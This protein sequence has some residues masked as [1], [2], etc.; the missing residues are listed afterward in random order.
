MSPRARERSFTGVLLAVV[1][2]VFI[3][4]MVGALVSFLVAVFYR[5]P[6]EGRLC[7]VL[8]LFVFAAVLVARISILEGRER[9]L[10]FG[11]ALALATLVTSSSLVTF[12]SQFRWLEPLILA[13]FIGVALWSVFQLTWDCTV[14]DQSR[15][16]SAMGWTE[17][18]RQR[19]APKSETEVASHTAEPGEPSPTLDRSRIGSDVQAG[20]FLMALWRGRDRRNTPGL[21]VLYFALGALPL[22]A[23]GQWFV[24]PSRQGWAMFLFGIY[25][26]A[27]LGLMT[28][29]S[30]LGL[31]RYLNLRQVELP[32][33]VAGPWLGIGAGIGLLILMVVM[34]LPRLDV[35]S[36]VASSLAWFKSTPRPAS[37]FSLGNDGQEQKSGARTQRE[38][39]SPDEKAG[40][41]K[42]ESSG[43][44]QAG[45]RQSGTSQ[46]APGKG[47]SQPGAKSQAGTQSNAKGAPPQSN[48]SGSQGNPQTPSA[49][50]A[51]RAQNESSSPQA[52]SQKADPTASP[53]SNQQ[54]ERARQ[55]AER[56]RRRQEEQRQAQA[57]SAA[58]QQAASGNSSAEAAQSTGQDSFRTPQLENAAQAITSLIYLLGIGALLLAAV[59]YRRELAAAWN[60]L[61]KAWLDWFRGRPSA[62]SPE[63]STQ[64]AAVKPVVRRYL[65]YRNPF[66]NGIQMPAN[67]LVKYSF[68]AFEALAAELNCGRDPQATPLEFSRVAMS[69]VGALNPAAGELAEM[70]CQV[71]YGPERTPEI[72]HETL[73]RVWELMDQVAQ[74]ELVRGPAGRSPGV[75]I[76][77]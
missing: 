14:M 22:F 23:A 26:A 11:V 1:G 48:P 36:S 31:Q 44:Q 24:A 29:T 8:G 58:R 77:T 42:S 28:L 62:A 49:S 61:W 7:L 12:E 19:W 6:H 15:D 38:A 69:R 73:R 5:G 75:A 16:N 17:R 9:A 68:A 35:E 57:S 4:F 10:L 32:V 63:G 53:D 66:S 55:A 76:S 70:I 3:M 18:L 51:S 37:E 27:A 41:G 71:N 2:P 46:N 67:E 74:S 40:T 43:G 60:S 20:N 54:R 13:G 33:A 56:E 25:L 52:D 30:L 59:L 64:A 47:S 45:N 39:Q 34:S 65:D 72:S 21:W 50:E